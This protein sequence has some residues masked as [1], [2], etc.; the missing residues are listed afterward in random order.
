MTGSLLDQGLMLLVFG[1]GTVFLFLG[2][3]VVSTY[4]MSKIVVKFFP[5]AEIEV[6]VPQRNL[7]KQNTDSQ[8]IS[9]ISAAIHRYRKN[10]K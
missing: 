8:L 5:E 4:S 7:N 9:V 6:V 10:K 1:M 3:L 2:I